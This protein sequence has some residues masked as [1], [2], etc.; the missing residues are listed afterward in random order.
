MKWLEILRAQRAALVEQRNAALAA[1]E[2]VATTALDEKRDMTPDEVIAAEEARAA[3]TKA[4][5]ELGPLE[6]RI[7][8][9]EA[10]EVRTKAVAD[11]KGVYV[12]KVEDPADVLGDRSSTPAQLADAITRAIEPRTDN[13]ENMA[14]ARSMLVRN[15]TDLDDD[16]PYL[17]EKREW[18]RRLLA[19][20][21]PVYRSAFR[22]MITGTGYNLT[23]AERAAIAVGTNTAGGYLVPTYLDPT[24]MLTNAGTSNAIRGAARVVDLIGA[25][26]WHGIT[27]AGSTASWDG[28][29]A[30]V[31]DD[32]P[33]FTG[34]SIPTYKAQ[35]FIQASVESFDDIAGLTSDVLM[36][37][38]DARDRLEGAAHATGSGS[39]QPTGI[40]TAIHAVSG[41]RI[42]STT[43]AAIGLVDIHALYNAVP[44]R[45]RKASTWVLA[46]V[47]NLAI[48]ALGTA[49]SASYSTNLL[50]PPAETYLGRP[51]IQTD[52]A[53]TVQTTTALDDE[54]LLGDL[55]N[56]II[57][58]KPG[59]FAIEFIPQLFNT[60]NNL[61]DGRKGWFAHW[62]NGA[63][64]PVTAAFRILVDKTTA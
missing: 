61:P 21:T 64:A 12:P 35:N 18:A 6:E 49:L 20:T 44:V 38:A 39:G 3:V 57:V 46:P 23:E 7:G 30:E 56:Y 11:H 43:G 60:A 37:L 5:D 29:V 63:D 32:T 22:K 8:E 52:D 4:D 51:V 24:V 28:E 34:P 13:A 1:M 36:L 15:L 47:Y 58:D 59:S 41:D 54:V 9:L 45:W 16:D 17:A 26:T 2:T 40:F 31:S 10:M 62:R 55:S 27:S 25:N 50:E 48:K 19:R 33:A 14:H 53:P 42:V